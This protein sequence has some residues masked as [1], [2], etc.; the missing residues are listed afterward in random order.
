MHGDIDGVLID[1]HAIAR[2]VGEL[3]Q[4]ILRDLADDA[5][6]ASGSDGEPPV[7][8]IVPVL[9]GSFIFVADLIR[10]M[11]LRMQIRL[12]SVSSY[13]GASTSSRGSKLRGDLTSLPDDLAG[14]HVLL[15]DDILDSGGTI[16]LARD[17]I[18]QRRPA[19]LRTCVLLRKDRPREP[20]VCVDYACFDIPDR[21]VVGY[22]L[23]CNDYYRNLPDIVTLRAEVIE[24]LATEAA[25]A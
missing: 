23:D 6:P 7:L 11:P 18:A 13:P 22:G 2:R 10:H 14:A 16:T 5:A 12:M 3:A 4:T 1:R 21:F 19:S 20:E 8:T 9:T 24:R 25:R 15:I 17:L